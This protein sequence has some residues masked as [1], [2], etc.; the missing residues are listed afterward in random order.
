M[1]YST[2]GLPVP[3]HFLEFAQVHVHCISDAI[4][5]SHPLMPFSPSALNLSQHHRLSQRSSVHIR[6]PGGMLDFVF[7]K[8]ERKQNPA[9][10]LLIIS[11]RLTPSPLVHQ[12]PETRETC[13]LRFSFRAFAFI[14]FFFRPEIPFPLFFKVQISSSRDI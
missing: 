7:S 2:P 13:I 4:Q 14:F 8:S 11:S 3:H 9:W 1:D 10:L 12:A 5:P 6:L